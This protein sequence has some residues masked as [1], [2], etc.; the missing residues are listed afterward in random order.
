MRRPAHDRSPVCAVGASLA[1]IAAALGQETA[2]L[3]QPVTIRTV[4]AEPIR[5]RL[6]ALSLKSGAVLREGGETRD[7]PLADI[8]RVTFQDRDETN[9]P[10]ELEESSA[11]DHTILVLASGDMLSG[12]V[13]D[14]RQDSVVLQTVD[15]GEVAVPMDA[16]ARLTSARA[17]TAA[18][19]KTVDWFFRARSAEEDA[20]LLT[21]GDVI[22]GFI[23]GIDSEG[24]AIDGPSGPVTA[25][26]RL[27]LAA[28]ISHPSSPSAAAPHAVV[29]FQQSGRITVT[30]L[31]CDGESVEARMHGGPLVR[32]KADRIAAID[33]AGGR[34]VWLTELRPLSF[35]QV[36]MLALG[37]DFAIDRNVRGAPLTVAGVA[38]E[39]GIGVHSRSVLIY[40][41]DGKYREF[42]TSFGI[43]DDSGPLADVNVSIL[44]DGQRRHE[45]AH[46]RRGALVGP[47]RLDVA[48]AGR[49]ELV[50]DFGDNG[51]VQDRFDWIE[52]A[53][54]R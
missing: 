48:R 44:V 32:F 8:V 24:L 28:R 7:V 30:S 26:H 19:R 12:K 21:N 10:A 15:V 20:V 50:V 9:P 52:P 27:V 37:W 34:W 49:I 4:R 41:L 39:H 11:G 45:S 17:A 3:R 5:S 40:E 23:T 35:E 6:A 42:V 2:P 13:V 22:R 18:F 43:D 16:L 54:I 31:E 53:L 51:D 36:P 38:Y 46:L 25:P 1:L 33:V 47:V 14:S 29:H